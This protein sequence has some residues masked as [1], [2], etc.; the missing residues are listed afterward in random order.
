M[1]IKDDFS[2]SEKQ[3]IIEKMLRKDGHYQSYL[4]ML[5]NEGW[6]TEPIEE[7]VSAA[8]QKIKN[9]IKSFVIYGEPQCVKTGMMIGLTSKLIDEGHE[10]II[11]LLNDSLKL[12]KQNLDRFVNSYIQPTAHEITE[13]YENGLINNEKNIIFCK[14]N[15]RD[16]KKLIE[17]TKDRKKI[18]IDD[19]ADYASPNAKINKNQRTAINNAIRQTINNKT[20]IRL[21]YF[22]SGN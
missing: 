17:L 2:K 20:V 3:K 21:I 5:I 7:T 8:I 11:I 19:E 9:N 18:I 6:E 22:I 4:E 14:K 12:L 10:F 13:V 16:L 1:Q 15:I